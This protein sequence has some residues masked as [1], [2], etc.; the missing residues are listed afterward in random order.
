VAGNPVLKLTPARGGKIK[1]HALSKTPSPRRSAECHRHDVQ[2][3]AAGIS[4]A[5]NPSAA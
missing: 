3:F 5:N 2:F 1:L 4:A